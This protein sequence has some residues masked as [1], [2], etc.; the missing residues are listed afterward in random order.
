ML[1][2]LVQ[3]HMV[4]DYFHEKKK[5]LQKRSSEYY[6]NLSEDNK[7]K[8]RNY[9]NTKN[10]SISGTDRGIKNNIRKIIIIKD[11]ICLII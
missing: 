2:F 5:K 3:Q 7:N 8:T 6:K 4:E 10:K 1:H 11:K 9:A